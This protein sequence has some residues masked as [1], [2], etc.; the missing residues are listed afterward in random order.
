MSFK[1]TPA[2]DKN[3]QHYW[4]SFRDNLLKATP[5]DTSETPQVQKARIAKLEADDEAWFSYY[6]PVYAFAE[7]AP[8]H[9]AATKRMMKHSK[10]YEVRAWSRELAKSTRTMMEVLKLGVTGKVRNVLL[11]SHSADNAQE[12][13]T[14][15]MI[16]L[17]SNARLINDYGK[18]QKLGS[19][20]A[21]KFS[22][23]KGLS[24]KSIGAGQSPRGTRKEEARPD[25]ILIDD[26]DTDEECR[27]TDR[28]NTK[29]K[30]IE[31]ALIPTVSISGNKRIIFCG[32]IIAKDCCITRAIKIADHVDVINIRDK[33]GVSSWP[34]KNSEADIDYLLS[35]ISYEASQKEYYNNPIDK[36]DVFKEITYNKVPPIH[37]CDAVLVYADPATSNKEKSKASTKAVIV[38]G[39][40]INVYYVY[41]VWL[42]TGSNARFIDW[43]Y[44]A[45]VYLKTG[46]VDI[47]KIYIEN[48]SLQDPFYEQ[49]LMPLIFAQSKTTNQVLPIT[50][51]ARKKPEKYFRI[52]GTL[53]PLNRLGLLVFNL[54]QKE[55]PHMQRMQAQ[56]LAV[57]NNSKL[58]DGPDCLE[59]GV[60]ILQN[61]YSNVQSNMHLVKR[62]HNLKRI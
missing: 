61:N 36:G 54:A 43:L 14:P 15:Y 46:N 20:E 5:I 17:E 27:N 58:M 21:G 50:P 35:K 11:V 41:K 60:W 28:I 56:M 52:E 4:D 39:R 48:N 51:D 29:W 22:T 2:Q 40:K 31:E 9:K 38:I 19:W 62:K 1:N 8:F 55:D 34:T 53:E 47:K 44:A 18:Q 7:P 23:R 45:F 42:D 59:G 30:W 33:H 10:W 49:V 24:F 12:L 26:I 6:F 32:N 57:S 13:L 16:N 37:T 25:V 3:A